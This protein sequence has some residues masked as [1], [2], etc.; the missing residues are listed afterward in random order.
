M[1][2]PDVVARAQRIN[3]QARNTSQKVESGTQ[4]AHDKTFETVPV[5]RNFMSMVSIESVPESM[6]QVVP[7]EAHESQP[8]MHNESMDNQEERSSVDREQ[9]IR[10]DSVE[11]QRFLRNNDSSA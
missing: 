10:R 5:E 3:Q 8:S 9:M 7:E 11:R 1:S 4:M 2:D 6:P